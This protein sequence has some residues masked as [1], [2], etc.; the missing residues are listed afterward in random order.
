MTGVQTCALPISTPVVAASLLSV[1]LTRVGNLIRNLIFVH[2][3][4]SGDRS[5][6]VEPDEISFT[7]DSAAVYS[8]IPVEVL[9]RWAR[10]AFGYEIGRASCRERV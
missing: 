7:W 2:R 8:S 9:R 4:T 1:R 10:E 3:D 5:A 6:V